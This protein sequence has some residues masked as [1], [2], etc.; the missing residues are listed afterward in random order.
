MEP[1]LINDSTFSSSNPSLSE[2]W[3]HFPP[4]NNNKNKKKR[5]LALSG[6]SQNNNQNT[7]SVLVPGDGSSNNI[8]SEEHQQQNVKPSSQPHPKQDYIH[9]RARRGQATD[10]HSLAERVINNK[11]VTNFIIII[12]FTN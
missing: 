5:K 10:S 8:S 12:T 9:V 4:Q 3:P 7:T 11:L 1:P 2:I 6:S